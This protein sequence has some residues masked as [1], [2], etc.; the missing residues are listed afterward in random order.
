M[1]MGRYLALD[2]GDERIGV[3]ISDA[4][5]LLARPL[6]VVPRRA[7]PAS[8]VR[9]QELV[10]QHGVGAIIVGMPLLSDG[11]EGRQVESVKAYLRGLQAHV[12]IPIVT[13]DERGSTR[14]AT[15]IM[16]Q[17]QS[18]RRRQRRTSD[19]VAAAVI[20]QDYISHRSGGD[21]E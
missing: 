6:E 7:G 11:R 13:W 17:N 15:E 19:A 8:F 5:G 1:S 12:A 3:A 20:L 14:R 4:R 18:S 21:A 10:E 9:I 2:V 16:V